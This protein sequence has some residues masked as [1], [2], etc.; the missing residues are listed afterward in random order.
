MAEEGLAMQDIYYIYLVE[1]DF[2][3]FNINNTNQ[4]DT[5]IMIY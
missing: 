5:C 4:K 2:D 3:Y 1:L